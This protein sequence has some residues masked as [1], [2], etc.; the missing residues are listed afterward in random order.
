MIRI[1]GDTFLDTGCCVLVQCN[2]LFARTVS[3]FNSVLQDQCIGQFPDGIHKCLL[4]FDLGEWSFGWGEEGGCGAVILNV[5]D[6]DAT[7]IS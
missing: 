1:L 4:S 2:R 5:D 7:D 3:F 6:I